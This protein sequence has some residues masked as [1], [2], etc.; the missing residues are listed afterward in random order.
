MRIESTPVAN[1]KRPLRSSAWLIS[2][3]Q[4]SRL[5]GKIAVRRC[6]SVTGVSATM[7]MTTRNAYGGGGRD[8]RDL[9]TGPIH[10]GE[11][12]HEPAEKMTPSNPDTRSNRIDKNAGPRGTPSAAA[13]SSRAES[14]PT[15]DGTS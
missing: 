14:P 6:R 8:Q 7:K 4:I 10:Q 1:T 3:I 5:N 2:M 13:V 15:V 9:Q 11:R 12:R